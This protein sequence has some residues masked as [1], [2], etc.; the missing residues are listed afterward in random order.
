MSHPPV[1]PFSLSHHFRC[2]PALSVFARSVRVNVMPERLLFVIS[3]ILAGGILG[4]CIEL[5]CFLHPLT[6]PLVFLFWFF[7]LLLGRGHSHHDTQDV[8]MHGSPLLVAIPLLG[9]FLLFCFCFVC[10]FLLFFYFC[11]YVKRQQVPWLDVL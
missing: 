4:F 9:V 10:W 8:I 2:D 7:V 5:C 1:S 6:W 3:G 11:L